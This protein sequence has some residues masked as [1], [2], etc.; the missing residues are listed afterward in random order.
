MRSSFLLFDVSMEITLGQFRSEKSGYTQKRLC[1]WA[2]ATY[3]PMGKRASVTTTYA[4]EKSK[5]QAIN[6]TPISPKFWKRY[7]DDSSCVIKSDAVASFHDSLNSI[8][9][10]ISFTIEH[11]SNS[12]LLLH[13]ILISRDNGKLMVDIYRKPTHTDRYLDFHSHRP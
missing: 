1:P 6:V 3:L 12:Q 8:N 9:R 10:H 2:N 4:W 5:K 13:D 11:E 7:V